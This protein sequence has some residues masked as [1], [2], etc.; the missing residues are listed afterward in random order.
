[1]TVN[2]KKKV[3]FVLPSLGAGGAER[4]I[5][6]VAQNVD[7]SK[8]EAELV[9]I[10]F[11]KDSQFNIE[12]IDLHYLNKPR[13]L[14]SVPKL[15]AHLRHNRPD[16]VLSAIGHLNTIMALL[17][18]FFRKTK[19][20]GREVNVLSVLKNY[21]HTPKKRWINFPNYIKLC[22]P[23]LDKIICQ[24]ND[25]ANDL[26]KNFNID[27][28][29]IQVI[30]NPITGD[31]NLK[32]PGDFSKGHVFKLI[33]VGRLAKQKGHLRILEALK[34]LDLP[35]H[36]TI[37]GNGPEKDSIFAKLEEL[38]LSQQV[39]HV[40]HTNKVSDF[41]CESDLFVQGS[42][43]E[44]FP[45]ALLES[46]A[47]G[48]PVVA[49]RALGGID[50]IIEDGVN[51]YIAEDIEDFAHKITLVL[52]SLQQWAPKTVSKSVYEKYGSTVI[53]SK[54]NSLLETI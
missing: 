21:S 45:N 34:L 33:T 20:I 16:I 42:Y 25:M 49:Y 43:V 10:G 37:I 36:Y 14:A 26:I 12:G 50:E 27:P 53:M 46:C 28:L 44:G 17:S 6:Y 31:F 2:T 47:V 35:F 7:A 51:G 19:F 40:P 15:Y 4:V 9:I 29:K 22:Y 8:F 1:M 3:C 48:T 32:K 54:Y 5:S 38:G 11:E 13:V 18:P 39:T 30:N 41:L 23:L 52:S 24:S